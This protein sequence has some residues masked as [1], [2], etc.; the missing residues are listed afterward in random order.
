MGEVEKNASSSVMTVSFV[1]QSND[2]SRPGAAQEG[3]LKISKMSIGSFLWSTY[4]RLRD[5]D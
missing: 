5:H 1:E 3:I 4:G 2:N